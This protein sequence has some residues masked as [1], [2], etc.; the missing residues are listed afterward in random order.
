MKD[1]N[2]RT[3]FDVAS[4]RNQPNDMLRLLEIPTPPSSN[5]FTFLDDENDRRILI[6]LADLLRLDEPEL[7]YHDALVE[8]LFGFACL[9][10]AYNNSDNWDPSI[11]L[12][13][14]K[15][16]RGIID[17]LISVDI[18]LVGQL[19]ELARKHQNVTNAP[20]LW[21]VI[22]SEELSKIGKCILLQ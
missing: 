1:R 22:E 2:G 10:A 11:I 8:E 15:L 17:E 5:R 13:P 9:L 14:G 7:L 4:E 21:S 20:W 16:L 18:E 3:P 6:G 19:V 12:T